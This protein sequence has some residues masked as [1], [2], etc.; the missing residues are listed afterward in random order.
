MNNKDCG[1]AKFYFVCAVVLV[2]IIY[3]VVFL[4]LFIKIFG[5]G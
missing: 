1:T 5:G 4:G 3:F 2:I